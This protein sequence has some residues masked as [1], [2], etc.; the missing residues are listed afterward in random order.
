MSGAVSKLSS[1]LIIKAV[2]KSLTRKIA[3]EIF[4]S[5]GLREV[6]SGVFNGKWSGNGRLIE[7]IDPST[8]Q[9]IAK[10]QTVNK[11]AW[12]VPC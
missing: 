8:N 6:N 10:I 1:S 12:I 4:P 5:L 11:H 9:V 3:D 2:P 7:S